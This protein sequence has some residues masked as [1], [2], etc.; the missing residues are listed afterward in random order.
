MVFLTKKQI[1]L[2]GNFSKHIWTS[3]RKAQNRR[4]G[5]GAEQQDPAFWVMMKLRTNFI[6]I[7]WTLRLYV[8]N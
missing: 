8:R 7:V 3:L 5:K 2:V 1:G 6:G 4:R